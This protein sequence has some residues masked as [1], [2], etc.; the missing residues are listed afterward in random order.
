MK[1]TPEVPPPNEA[2]TPNRSRTAVRSRNAASPEDATEARAPAT[3]AAIATG[4]HRIAQ[5]ALH[6]PPS[7]TAAETAAALISL[8][9]QESAAPVEDLGGALTRMA[10]TLAQAAGARGADADPAAWRESLARDLAVCVES[11]QFHDRLIQQLAQVRTLLASIVTT[12]APAMAADSEDWQV[13]V[14]NLRA[15]FT[16]ESHRILFNLL[17]PESGGRHPV[18]SLHA[19]EGSVELF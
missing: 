8:A 15:R 7:T 1:R 6:R 2:A 3:I 9:M 13:L 5:G 11:L 19:N 4:T 14:E 17:L 16:S 18:P 12:G 10:Q